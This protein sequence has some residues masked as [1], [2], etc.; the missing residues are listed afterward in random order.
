M[1]LIPTVIT[2]D[3]RGERAYDIYSRLLKDGVIFVRGV[4]DSLGPTSSARLIPSG[5]NSNAHART[6]AIGKPSAT[7]ATTTFITQAG[8]SNV[9]KRIDAAWMSSQAITAYATAT[10]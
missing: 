1:H 4:I 3:G 9:G 7:T 10:L 8:A 2:N 6:S 5:V